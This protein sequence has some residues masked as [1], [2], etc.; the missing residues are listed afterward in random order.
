MIKNNPKSFYAILFL[1]LTFIVDFMACNP[2]KSKIDT[3]NIKIE[4]DFNRFEKDLFELSKPITE[5]NIH[6][7]RKKYPEFFD[8]FCQRIIRIPM[9]NDSVTAANLNLFILDK[10]VMAIYKKTIEVFPELNAVQTELTQ[11]LKY[12][13]YYWP[14]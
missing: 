1:L 6:T 12:F 4:L 11:V 7:L 9:E 5:G 13:H 14:A 10:D 2:D 3:G 8:V